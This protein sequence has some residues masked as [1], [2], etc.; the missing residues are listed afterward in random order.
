MSPKPQWWGARTLLRSPYERHVTVVAGIV[1]RV[2]QGRTLFG[3]AGGCPVAFGAELL[4]HGLAL[5]RR[6]RQGR[7][8]HVDFVFARKRD[9]GTESGADQR[10]RGCAKTKKHDFL[11]LAVAT[12][13]AR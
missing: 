10:K 5:K 4:E 9:D 6:P 8:D 2:D 12:R 3:A 11:T 13:P 1:E 7:H